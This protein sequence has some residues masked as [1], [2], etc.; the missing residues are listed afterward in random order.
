MLSGDEW[1]ALA[2][3]GPVSYAL[4]QQQNEY[5]PRSSEMT[6]ADQLFDVDGCFL[7]RC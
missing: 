3:E 2:L 5:V 1:V 6:F 4:A 7:S